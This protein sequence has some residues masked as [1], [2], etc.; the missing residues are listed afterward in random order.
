MVLDSIMAPVQ[1]R[2][3]NGNGFPFSPRQFGPAKHQITVKVQVRHQYVRAQAV[4]FQYIGDFSSRPPNGGVGL[5]ERGT[6]LIFLDGI[7]PSHCSTLA[8]VFLSLA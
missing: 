7:Y 4:Y 5:S 2:N 3:A 8:S 6:T 1:N